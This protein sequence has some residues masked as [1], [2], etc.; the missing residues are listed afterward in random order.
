M[1]EAE[2]AT[3]RRSRAALKLALRIGVA[4]VALW[5]LFTRLPNEDII[6]DEH[7]ALTTNLLILAL[8]TGLLGVVLSAWRWQ[9]VLHL[10]DT[11]VPLRTLTLHYL[12]GLFVGN[13]LPSTVGG[14]FVRVARASRTIGSPQ[15][16]FGS[17]V[18][19]RLTGFVALPALVVVGF[20]VRPSLIGAGHAWIA[21]GVAALTLVIL[22][23]LLFIAGHPRIAGRYADHDNWMRSI[24]AIHSGIDRLRRDPRQV[25]PVLG[26]ALVYQTSVV[27]MFALIFRALD[28]PVPIA[29]VVAFTPAVLMIQVAPI[30]L[31]GLGIREGALVLF[32]RAYLDGHDVPDSRLAAAGLLW[33]GCMLVVSMLG[34]PAFI[35]GNNKPVAAP[36]T[37]SADRSSQ[38]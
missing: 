19:E 23:A 5:I 28:L 7:V 35:F 21:L 38:A 12:V 8:F 2:A 29:A 16:S 6:P 13:F 37:T 1:T 32:F 31:G 14:D 25:G 34:A 26:T 10:L 4:V 11:D 3:P 17:V 30:S 27:V 15:T 22:G 18:L 24:G 20:I 9:R 33:Y 36:V